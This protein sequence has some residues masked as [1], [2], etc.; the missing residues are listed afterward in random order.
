MRFVFPALLLIATSAGACVDRLPEQDLRIRQAV[1]VAKMSPDDLWNDFQK[2]PAAARVKYWGKAIEISGKP[3]R[4]DAQDSTGPYL[5]FIGSGEFGVRANL[6][7]EDAPE[8]LKRAAAGERLT[9]RCY[10]EGL[11]GHVMLKSCVQP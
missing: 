8:I 4:T 1:P 9:L 11:Q 10:C 5:L 7:D 2:D 3:T 6:L